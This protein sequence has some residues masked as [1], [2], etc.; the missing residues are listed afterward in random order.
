MADIPYILQENFEDTTGLFVD[1][2]GD[3]LDTATAGKTTNGRLCL[4]R[5]Q[6]SE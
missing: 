2:S 4:E 3:T 5:A 1:E 6:H